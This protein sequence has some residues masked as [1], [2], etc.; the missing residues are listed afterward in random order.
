MRTIQFLLEKAI[1]AP[2]IT[3]AFYYRRDYRATLDRYL[4]V[5][6]VFE[7]DKWYQMWLTILENDSQEY[8]NLAEQAERYYQH[9]ALNFAPMRTRIWHWATGE[10]VGDLYPPQHAFSE[11]EVLQEVDRIAQRWGHSSS[12]TRS[13]VGDIKR[14]IQEMGRRTWLARGT[15]QDGQDGWDLSIY[16]IH[17]WDVLWKLFIAT[18]H[19]QLYPAEKNLL[20]TYRNFRP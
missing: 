14:R 5:P 17:N 10:P 12:L 15:G 7:P 2:R 3:D 4:R 18:N 1:E 8:A 16:K 6:K 11:G 19:V 13:A 20:V 9:W